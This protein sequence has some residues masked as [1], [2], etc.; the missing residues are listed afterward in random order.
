MEAVIRNTNASTCK[1]CY[2]C[3][4][5]CPSKAIKIVG[6]LARIEKNRCVNCGQCLQ[7]CK[8]GEWHYNRD[9]ALV[10]G[11]LNNDGPVAVILDTAFPAAYPDIDHRS[12]VG[13]LRTL[14]FDYVLDAAFGGDLVARKQRETLGDPRDAIRVSSWCPA[15]VEFVK[16]FHPEEVNLLAPVVSPMVA[17]GQVVKKLHGKAC[18]IV[19]IS[20]CLAHKAI[21]TESKGLI[22]AVLTFVELNE[23]LIGENLL[24]DD[25]NDSEISPSDFDPPHGQ[26]AV[27]SALPMGVANSAGYPCNPMDTLVTDASGPR[28]STRVMDNIARGEIT[29]GFIDMLFCR[30]CVDGCAISHRMVSRYEAKNAVLRYAAYRQEQHNEETWNNDLKRFRGLKLHMSI[31]GNDQRLPKAD[32]DRVKSIGE[33]LDQYGEHQFIDCSACGYGTCVEFITSVAKGLADTD[34]CIQYQLR[35]LNHTIKD[36]ETTTQR[37]TS[38]LDVLH[39]SEKL[40]N[41]AQ[42]SAA[43]AFKL[44][45][46]LSVVMLYSHLLQ[47][48]YRDHP[49]LSEDFNTIVQQVEK[50]KEIFIDLLNLSSR[51]KILPESVDVRELVDRTLMLLPPPAG[52]DVRLKFDVETPMAV[53]DREQIAC[54]LSNLVENVYETLNNSGQM[55]IH[56]TGD[57][58]NLIIRIS[59]NGP[60]IRKHDLIK[61]FDPFFTTKRVGVGTGLGLA[62]AREII[63][64]HSGKIDVTSNDNPSRGPTGTTF[65]L[66]IPTQGIEGL[67]KRV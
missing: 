31:E 29:H 21:K 32:T 20:P 60:G 26:L 23:I 51:N 7:V 45:D 8:H 10:R 24:G 9:Q 37:L 5:A 2:A 46:P 41:L 58:H 62:V 53:M 50:V 17:M 36:Q 52:M 12:L 13:R 30:G 38:M 34:M 42:L 43:T 22:A 6:G 55:T 39:H 64:Q 61:I 40:A 28:R 3:V 25:Y 59:D 66:T 49:E 48:E 65:Q 18:S 67:K 47:E 57:T 1:G 44:N 4:R 63:R 14:G 16:R 27:T 56:T 33:K 11:L 35:K 19:Y 54:V 15:S